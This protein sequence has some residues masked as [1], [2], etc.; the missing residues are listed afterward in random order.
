[1]IVPRAYKNMAMVLKNV[2]GSKNEEALLFEKLFWG[3]TSE[4]EA[5]V[6]E[7]VEEEADQEVEDKE[8][9][10]VISI[11]SITRMIVFYFRKIEWKN[12]KNNI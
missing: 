1:M 12:V 3:C 4:E 8:D 11:Y 6:V 2:D 5:V 7:E 10:A 9:V